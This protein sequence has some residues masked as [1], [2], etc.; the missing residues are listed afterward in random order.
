MEKG[1]LA[2]C[3]PVW[4]VLRRP[5][6]AIPRAAG[7]HLLAAGGGRSAR[8]KGEPASLPLCFV[9]STADWWLLASGDIG[10]MFDRIFRKYF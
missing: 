1:M 8:A 9:Q 7:R 5:R 2:A 4:S 3:Q 6:L 10:T